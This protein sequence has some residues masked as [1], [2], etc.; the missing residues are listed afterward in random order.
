[1]KLLKPIS[2]FCLSFLL[3]ISCKAPKVAI[4][5]AKEIQVPF[6][7][8]KYKSDKDNLRAK[9]SGTSPDLATAKKIAMQNA[10][11]ELAGNIQS[12]VKRVTD[13]FTN[14]R[15]VG[16]NQEF[17]NK[18]EELSR[19]VVDQ[20]LSDIKVMDEKIFQEQDKSFTY[21]LV[22]EISKE[23]MFNKIQSKISK[24]EKLQLDY[25]K[26]KFEEIFNNEMA[27]MG[28]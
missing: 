16:S 26:K 13:Q 24:N 21:W 17:E 10:K 19:E 2:I 4:N 8:S 15:T 11:S 20:T 1:M 3:L 23:T 5:G 27:K 18:F 7:D 9:Q 22:I 6:M 28:Q 14:Q 25:D 12:L